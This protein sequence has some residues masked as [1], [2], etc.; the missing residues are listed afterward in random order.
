M[1]LTASFKQIKILTTSG[2]V[3][4]S[5][6][7]KKM[8]TQVSPNTH[9]AIITTTTTTTTATATKRAYLRCSGGGKGSCSKF[10]TIASSVQYTGSRFLYYYMCAE[11]WSYMWS[12]V[13]VGPTYTEK[14]ATWPKKRHHE[15]KTGAS[16]GYGEGK[17]RAWTVTL[18][19]LR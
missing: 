5:R 18:L 3:H 14:C 17:A 11:I 15:G 2:Y 10:F 13:R 1:V 9:T 7:T 16:G 6:A 4:K 12:G 19:A 8:T